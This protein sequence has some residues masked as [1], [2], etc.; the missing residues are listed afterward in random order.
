MTT[1]WLCK[2]HDDLGK[3]Q[4]YAILELRSEVFV[5]EQKCAYQDVD[6]QDLSGDT[7][8]VMGWQDD[9]LVAYAR[10]LDPES[11]GGDVVI[12]RVIIAPQGRGQKLGHRL[13]EVALESIEEYWSGQPIFMSAQAH[14]QSF[15][16][17]HG[18][19]AE[20]ETYLEDDIPHIGMRR[21]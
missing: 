6:G 19:R 15:Y 10:L 3:E 2:H 1:D 16:E 5:V 4:L 11:Q 13:L 14:L 12:G 17:Q 9:K 20:G 7:L 21:A 8:H 18:F